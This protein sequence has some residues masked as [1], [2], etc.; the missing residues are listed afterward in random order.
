MTEK[1]TRRHDSTD[2]RKQAEKVVRRKGAQLPENVEALSRDGTLRTLH[3]LQVHQIELE[4]QNEE[5]RRAQEELELSRN[6]YSELYD[7]APVGYV[8]IDAR[9]LIEGVNLKG[10]H[11]LGIERG[12]LLKR[13]FIRFIEDAAD[14]EIFSRH[15]EEVLQKQGNQICE[16]RLK[17]KYGTPFHA[18]LQSIT[19]ESIDGKAGDILTAIIDITEHKKAE[20]E[21]EHLA[22]F[23][24]LNPN[25]V[26]ETD[27]NG[28]VI[29]CNAA[30]M[31]I[32]EKLDATEDV[33][34]FL[35]RDLTEIVKKMLEQG[36]EG[37]YFSREV[38]INGRV[39]IENITYYAYLK[40]VRIY[41]QDITER[42]RAE[43]EKRS[44]EERLHRAEKMEA[45][46][47]LAG[48][49]AHDLNNLLG[50]L[51]GNAEILTSN[52]RKTDPQRPLVE[53]IMDSG[54]R[55]AA[56]VQDLLTMARRGV[57]LREL[58]SLNRIVT[59]LLKTSEIKKMF[60]SHPHV[61]IETQYDRDLLDIN[62]SAIHI[63]RALTNLIMN[64]LHAIP[65]KGTITIRTENRYLESPLMGYEEV[66]KGEYAVLSVSDTGSG[67]LPE[68]MKHLFE[69]FYMRKVLNKGG[70]GRGLSVIWGALKDHNGYIDVTSDPGKGT[71]FTLYFPATRDE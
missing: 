59:D 14:R 6:K 34:R 8:T 53:A 54:Q 16:I 60:S 57:V 55:A 32:F 69:P 64:A 4:M 65:E 37:Q 56:E 9:G 63:E 38:E 45:I 62:A 15:L 30:T 70:T 25:P 71:I 10:A 5:L 24:Q 44:L 20:E 22:S 49:V 3:E 11:L 43:E 7:F 31:S 21:I 66:P 40:V 28:Q 67:I 17:R 33:R 18:Q 13:P 46:G 51:I 48:G 19:K 1:K 35:P 27:L 36:N 42:K 47:T 61:T 41:A 26:I 29:F 12:L 50:V 58:A 23:P 52:M 39:F 68:H 2:F